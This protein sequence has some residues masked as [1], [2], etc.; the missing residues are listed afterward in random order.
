MDFKLITFLVGKS[1]NLFGIK[2]SGMERYLTVRD[3]KTY[4][5]KIRAGH[6]GKLER[7]KAGTDV[8]VMF[9]VHR[10]DSA[11]DFYCFGWANFGGQG[12]KKWKSSGYDYIE[13]W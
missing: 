8:S 5:A 10:T 13:F 4:Y 12:K 2:W 1:A 6:I 7:V 3:S 9:A 11:F